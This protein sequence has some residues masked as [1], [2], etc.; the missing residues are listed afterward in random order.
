M[1]TE[2]SY[3]FTNFKLRILNYF[4]NFQNHMQKL[5]NLLHHLYYYL[6]LNWQNITSHPLFPVDKYREQQNFL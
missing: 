1:I 4:G 3:Y 5:T 2:Q 6:K